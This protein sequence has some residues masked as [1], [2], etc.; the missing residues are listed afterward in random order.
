MS[1]SQLMRVRSANEDDHPFIYATWLKGLRYGNRFYEYIDQD[2]YFKYYQ[3]VIA[4]LLESPAVQIDMAVLA[5]DPAVIL[6]YSV[7]Q[8]DRLHWVHVKKAWRGIGIAKEIVPKKIKQIS[9][10][11]DIAVK[12]L[13][14][15]RNTW[16]F[17]P[18]L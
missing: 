14:K 15:N 11:T 18:F 2:T 16:I 17:N 6:G 13:E 10:L 9:H 3:K 5:D 1:L 4:A 12:I 7:S 8:D